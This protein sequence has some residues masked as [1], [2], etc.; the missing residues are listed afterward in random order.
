LIAS[1]RRHLP[2]TVVAALLAATLSA[3]AWALYKV[4]NPDG[5]VTYTDRPP[6]SG[7]ARIT[8]LGRPG[9]A[10]PT[11]AGDPALPAELR[12]PV[13]RY[14][15]VLYTTADCTPCDTGRQFLQRRGIPYAERRAS[16]DEDS[17]ALE[18]I[19]GGRTVPALMVG[20]QPLRGFSES[21]WTAY[22]DAAGYPR[23]SRLPR[24]WQPS[25]G[26]V[27][28]RVAAPNR[29]AAA[30]APANDSDSA[31]PAPAPTPAPAPGTLRF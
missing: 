24:N 4:V 31:A 14:P 28:E 17:L 23:E 6:A 10:A 20:S 1:A 13:L 26:P 16:T 18:R 8:P 30:P 15:V 22:L 7:N 9:V 25:V 12:Q 21:D 5:T 29:P 19:V 11:G 27:V 3:P 2:A